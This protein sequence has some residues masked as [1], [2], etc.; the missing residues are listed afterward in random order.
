MNLSLD[1]PIYPNQQALLPFALTDVLIESVS[2]NKQ[3]LLHFWQ[4]KNTMILGMKDTRVANLKQGVAHLQTAGYPPVVRS[5]GG[6]GVISDPDVLNISLFIPQ[7]SHTTSSAY[8][9]MYRLTQMAFP[10]LAIVTGEVFDSYCPG[11]YDLSCNGK[12]IAG[13]AQRKIKAGIA[14]MMYLSVSGAQQNR[15]QIVRDFYLTSL[16]EHFGQDGYPPVNP[17]SMTTVSDMLAEKITIAQTKE[18]FLTA[19]SKLKKS[20]VSQMDSSDW[21]MATENRTL[22]EEKLNRMITRNQIL[23]TL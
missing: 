4:L 6:L 8:E 10:E 11:T 9:E 21:L 14:I 19:F 20:N 23:E 13:I 5:A 3:P 18:R 2:Q 22:Y 1:Q 15:G 16:K 7:G 12:K 17:A